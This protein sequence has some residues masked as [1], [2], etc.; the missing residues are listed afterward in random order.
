MLFWGL[1]FWLTVFTVV[2][3]IVTGPPY[4]RFLVVVAGDALHLLV[5]F[6]SGRGEQQVALWHHLVLHP[7]LLI[8]EIRVRRLVLLLVDRRERVFGSVLRDDLH[9]ERARGGDAGSKAGKDDLVDIGD[10]DEHG[11]L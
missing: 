5:R 7:H 3:V 9:V 6:V 1:F 4:T 11:L 8:L 2:I 10:F